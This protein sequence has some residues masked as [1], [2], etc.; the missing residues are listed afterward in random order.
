MSIFSWIF[1]RLSIFLNFYIFYY[2][3]FDGFLLSKKRLPKVHLTD[4]WTI[5]QNNRKKEHNFNK[6][7]PCIT[8]QITL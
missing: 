1:S 5:L 3:T 7:A 4:K 2:T 6:K 8:L